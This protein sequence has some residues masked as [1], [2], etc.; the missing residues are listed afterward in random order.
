MGPSTV[1]SESYCRN[2]GN[3]IKLSH[4]TR[5]LDPAK[6]VSNASLGLEF[7]CYRWYKFQW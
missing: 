2:V 7:L 1:E 6:L 4:L 5:T 3:W